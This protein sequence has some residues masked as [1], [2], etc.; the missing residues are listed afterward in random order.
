MTG[1]EIYDEE[2]PKRSIEK[3]IDQKTLSKIRE[4]KSTV[5]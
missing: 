2:N 4:E 5:W 3:I 1:F